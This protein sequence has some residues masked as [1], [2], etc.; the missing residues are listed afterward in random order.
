MI[1]RLWLSVIL[2]A[3]LGAVPFAAAQVSSAAT[4]PATGG[5]GRAA[6]RGVVYD[7]VA[8][9]ALAGALVQLIAADSLAQF[10]RTEVS[11]SLGRFAFGDVPNGRYTLGFFHPMLD[12]LG[13]EPLLR[14]VSV[15]GQHLVRADLAIP[16]PTR[17]RAA[18]CGPSSVENSAAVVMGFVRDARSGAPAAGVRVM[19]EWVELSIGRGGVVRTSPRRVT[20]TRDSGWFAI[21]NVPGPGA[22]VLMASRSADSTDFVEVQVPADGFLRRDLYLGSARTEIPIDSVPSLDSVAPARRLR[23]GDGLLRGT[24]VA[25]VGGRPLFGAQVGITDGPQARANQRGEWTI[26]NAPAGTRTLEVRSVGF[27]PERQ[28]VDVIDGAPPVRVALAT[29]KA[30]LDTM[31]VIANYYRYSNLAGFRERSRTGLGRFMTP[32]DIARRQP[33]V[34]TDLFRNFPGVFLDGP[35]GFDQQIYMRGVF[36]DR[37]VP[38]VFLNG[39]VMNGVSATDVDAFVDPDDIVGIEVYSQS[40]APAQFQPGLTGCGSIVIWTR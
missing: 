31:K 2:L 20:T 25:A 17:L 39:A 3:H 6:V 8:G 11:D 1:Q 9:R 18:I 32:A 21:C 24:V 26:V 29:F 22:M 28:V 34:T 14:A 40:Q 7:S 10:G 4:R 37:C 5:A 35:R 33:L 12:S 16:A 19:G 38:S 23:V 36:V 30:V 13:L 27:Y 15:D